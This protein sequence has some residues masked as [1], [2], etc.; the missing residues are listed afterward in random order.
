MKKQ[1]LEEPART[2]LFWIPIYNILFYTVK[3]ILLDVWDLA[4]TVGNKFF[5]LLWVVVFPFLLVIYP[6]TCLVLLLVIIVLLFV[7]LVNYIFGGVSYVVDSLYLKIHGIGLVCPACNNKYQLPTY[8]CPRC[9]A[10]HKN[11]RPG[12]YGIAK[13]TCKCGAKLPTTF[14]NGRQH[15]DAICPNPACRY[16]FKSK[17]L[18]ARPICI[19]II[20]GVSSGK[21][22]LINAGIDGLNKYCQ[23]PGNK[24]E[25]EYCSN[26]DEQ[27]H[28]RNLEIL[29]T[30]N[31]DK[32]HKQQFDSYKF[33]FS[34]QGAKVKN[35]VYVYDV[36]GEVYDAKKQN[37]VEKTQVFDFTNSLLFVLDPLSI[38]DFYDD[39]VQAKVPNLERYK[40]SDRSMNDVVTNMINSLGVFE[41][42]TP[43]R[44][45][46]VF[47]AIVITKG[48]LPLIKDQIGDEYVAE[49]ARQNRTTWNRAK[50]IAC[51]QFLDKYQAMN[52]L[53]IIR[54][55][56]ENYQ[57]FTTSSWSGEQN[58]YVAENAEDP[59][60]WLIDMESPEIDLKTKWNSNK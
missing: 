6:A 26:E 27:R 53:N 41:S 25:F 21:T 10:Q 34:P 23:I 9:N 37:I 35:R 49:L 45:K 42:L 51:E 22:S 18:P 7:T 31:T 11:L 13:R 15:L 33:Y 19:P 36:A 60:L 8:I 48:D 39:C 28:K 46:K 1:R 3:E 44:C 29:K 58:K 17:I 52:F 47:V 32:T 16:A 20:G 54:D 14:F 40:R 2:K 4:S 56:F 30:R 59:F 55:K 50:N 38:D 12:K 24:M 43:E 57:F 5:R